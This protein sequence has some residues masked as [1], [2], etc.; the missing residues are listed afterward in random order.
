M[1]QLK[2]EKPSLHNRLS[3]I[4]E[5]E[6]TSV[7][8]DAITVCR[9]LSISWLLTDTLCIVQDDPK[10]WER[11]SCTSFSSLV[12][13]TAGLDGS[14]KEERSRGEEDGFVSGLTIYQIPDTEN[15][16]RVGVFES[17]ARDGWGLRILDGCKTTTLNLI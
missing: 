5:A 7:L 14:I 4:L 16:L 13:S 3:G 15:F 1:L 10:D 2:T 12:G 6:M 9:A 8:R 17:Y 11:D